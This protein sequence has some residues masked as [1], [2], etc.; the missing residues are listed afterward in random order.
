M[1]D[2]AAIEIFA[3]SPAE[4]AYLADIVRAAGFSK[5]AEAADLGLASAR[6]ELPA[7]ASISILR[8]GGQGGEGVRVMD[9]PARASEVIA[10]LQSM[11]RSEQGLPAKIFIGGYELDTRD[12]LW[13]KAGE[14]PLRLTEKETAILAHMKEAGGKPVSR[15][16]LLEH[17]WSYVP[18]VETHTLETHIYRLRQKIE[19]D[20]SSPKILITQGDGYV[21]AG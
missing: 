15:Q 2:S 9:S 21:L 19:D 17:V 8:I 6:A 5:A 18:D 10:L 3:A 12:N 20:P 13:T 16:E 4:S 11:V 14:P 7:N 1:P